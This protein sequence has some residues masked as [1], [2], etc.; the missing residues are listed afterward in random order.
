MADLAQPRV[1]YLEDEE[2]NVGNAKE[3]IIDQF[4]S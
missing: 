4:E 1:K 2:A 3:D